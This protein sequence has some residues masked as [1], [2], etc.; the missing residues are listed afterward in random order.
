MRLFNNCL[1]IILLGLSLT[2]C[3]PTS[4]YVPGVGRNPGLKPLKSVKVTSPVHKIYARDGSFTLTSEPFQ[5]SPFY[6]NN[7]ELS[8]LEK[9]KRVPGGPVMLSVL[10]DKKWVNEYLRDRKPVLVYLKGRIEPLFGL[11][12]IFPVER[13]HYAI[14]D[15]DEVEA[16]I[17]LTDDALTQMKTDGIGL[18]TGV[19]THSLTDWCQWAL[20][21]SREEFPK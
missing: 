3:A 20:W 7:I 15:S 12:A 10:Q 19:Y 9:F 8:F 17:T 18:S 5:G 11:L 6:V 21:I 4:I 14:W 2:S 16:T 13:S 1:A